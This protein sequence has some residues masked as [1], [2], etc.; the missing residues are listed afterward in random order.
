M[1]HST[2]RVILKAAWRVWQRNATVYKRTWKLNILPNFFEP[3]LYLLGMGIGLGAYINEMD[4]IPYIQYIAPGLLI[5]SIMWGASLET[6]YNVFVKMNFDRI[7]DGILS[8]PVN[9]KDLALGELLWGATRGTIY[10]G[11]FFSI[12]FLFGMGLHWGILLIIPLL[13]II[14]FLFATIGLL[15]T[16]VIKEIELFNYFFTLF[17]TPLFLFSG[18]FFPLTQLPEIIQ[19]IAWFT[20]LYHGVELSRGIFNQLWSVDLLHHFLWILT[21]TALNTVIVLRSIHKRLYQ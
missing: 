20:P 19:I 11:A 16:S 1:N 18:I 13:F 10:G 2:P 17:L 3:F 4:G 9:P 7:Y 6:T 14:G 8:T 12:L 21:V 5:S 15:F